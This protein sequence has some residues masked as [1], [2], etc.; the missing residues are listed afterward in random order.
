MKRTRMKFDFKNYVNDLR[1]HNNEISE[2]LK[3][4]TL[5]CNLDKNSG[6]ALNQIDENISDRYIFIERETGSVINIEYQKNASS[7][8]LYNRFYEISFEKAVWQLLPKG[9]NS[10]FSTISSFK[11]TDCDLSILDKQNLEQFGEFLMMANFSNNLLT[12]LS[13]DL[14]ENNK[15]IQQVDL[16]DNPLLHIPDNFLFKE[17][18]PLRSIE[19]NFR[20]VDCLNQQTMKPSKS[21]KKSE[22]FNLDSGNCTNSSMVINYSNL[23]INLLRKLKPEETE[24]KC[25][26]LDSCA[27]SIY[28]DNTFRIND[29]EYDCEMEVSSP[30]VYVSKIISRNF[31]DLTHPVINQQCIRSSIAVFFMNNE[32]LE[33]IPKK[34]V[35]I[36]KFKINILTIMHTSLNSISE[37]DMKP[38][39]ENLQR[40]AFT[41][42]KLQV[43]RKN[44]FKHNINLREIDL[45]SNPILYVASNFR[46][47]KPTD[48]ADDF[49]KKFTLV[50]K[51]P[52]LCR[53]KL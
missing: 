36:T 51:N 34:I 38:F 30:N 49:F 15:N 52:Y 21:S 45:E 9:F 50:V 6:Y 13:E 27:D 14:F 47:N 19:F 41:S 46:I 48:S 42:C 25:S 4:E 3:V 7:G 12:F 1:Q 28:Y 5:S 44:V 40:A 39:G 18:S 17:N 29:I 53:R 37:N 26:I 2:V 43:I 20:N 22:A 32:H 31:H 23:K 33:Y 8:E 16:S 10:V 11:I 24:M 35:D